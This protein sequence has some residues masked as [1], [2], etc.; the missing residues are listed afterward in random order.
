MLRTRTPDGYYLVADTA[1]PRG[2]SQIEGRIRAPI[3]AGQRIP[4]T[5]SEVAEKLAFNR[6]LLSYRQTAEWGMRALQGSF[7]RLRV[8]LEINQPQKR[9]N[10]LEVCVRLHN[11]R[12]QRVGINQICTVYMKEWRATDELDDLWRNFENILFSEQRARDRVS[13]YHVYATWDHDNN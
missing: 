7:G 1:F 10:L 2:T 3:K 6:E 11:L 5:P 12:A 13:Q 4:G 9:A 8:P